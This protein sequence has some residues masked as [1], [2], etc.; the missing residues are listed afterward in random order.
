[1]T[2]SV[3][4]A[5]S[6][7]NRFWFEPQQT[8]TLALFR[9]ALGLVAT[10]WTAS[11]APNLLAFYGP[12]GLV[13][14]YPY[15]G[16]WGGPLGGPGGWG[17]LALWNSPVFV[18]IVFAVTIAAS[19]ALTIG[20][21]SRLAAV[22]VFVGL[23]AFQRRNP[24]VWNAGDGL[25]CNL[26]L[27][28]ALAPSGVALSLDRLRTAPGRFWEFP[29]R[30]PW[31]LRMAQIQLSVVYL[32]TFWG[33]I[34]GETWRNGTAVSYA[35]RFENDHR[36]PI[37]AFIPDSVVISELLTFG[38]LALELSL[39]LLVWNRVL[40][41]WILGMG[42]ALHLGIDFAIHVGFFSF[43]MFTAY[44]TFVPPETATRLITVVRGRLRRSPEP[45]PEPPPRTQGKRK[46]TA[47]RGGPSRFADQRR[48]RPDP[49]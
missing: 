6:G 41:P 11:L 36:Y 46:P 8:S 33:K 5:V 16:P 10:L 45:E 3:A 29:T 19:L 40:R 18:G 22:V 48:G 43:V 14:E 47:N 9:I 13:P 39:G 1:V 21:R 23:L 24:W 2:G 4:R 27:F 38:T 28:C 15:S 26:A 20:L 49:R 32:S 34:Q 35:L 7:W 12:D 17:V 25:L 31:A 37:P 42:V 30:A 44:L